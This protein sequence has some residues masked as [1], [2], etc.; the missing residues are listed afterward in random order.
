[1]NVSKSFGAMIDGVEIITSVIAR[2]AK[3]EQLYLSESIADIWDD[4]TRLQLT[5]SLLKLYISILKYFSVA[6]R[7]FGKGSLRK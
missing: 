6:R 3:L 1:M 5:G 7:Y 4:A 2:C